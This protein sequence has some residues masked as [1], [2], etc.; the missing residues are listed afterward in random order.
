MKR[1]WLLVSSVGALALMVGSATASGPPVVNTTVRSVD[2]PFVDVGLDCATGMEAAITGVAT[3]AI[4]MLVLADGSVHVSGTFRGTNSYDDLPADG[5]PDATSRFV[6]HFNDLVFS[7]GRE[8]HTETLPGQ[9]TALATGASFGFHV[10]FHVV[11]DEN[12][13]PTVEILRIDCR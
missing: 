7:S 2:E 12:G 8:V 1:L 6:I 3:G 11:L 9:G 4:H 10:V 13:D 5:T